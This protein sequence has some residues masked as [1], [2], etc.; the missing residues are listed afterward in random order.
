MPAMPLFNEY[1]TACPI[2]P[3]NPSPQVL[4]IVAAE[5]GQG[6][7]PQTEDIGQAAKGCIG[8]GSR[9]KRLPRLA[10]VA[11]PVFEERAM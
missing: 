11:A 6:A 3:A 8:E 2:T 10:I 7:C 9:Q 5:S 4:E 1:S